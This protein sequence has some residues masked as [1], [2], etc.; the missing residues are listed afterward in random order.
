MSLD[1]VSTYEDEIKYSGMKYD[2]LSYDILADTSCSPDMLSDTSPLQS[3]GDMSAGECSPLQLLEGS[4]YGD[5]GSPQPEENCQSIIF[6][7]K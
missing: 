5:D 2:D 6:Y 4:T 3:S 1:R 7:I